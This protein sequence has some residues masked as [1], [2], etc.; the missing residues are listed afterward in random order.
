MPGPVGKH[1]SVRGR[2]NVSSTKATL[3]VD[4]D[5]EA[6]E[7]P[8]NIAWH[9]MVSR[10]WNDIWASPMAPEY[11]DSDVNGLFRRAVGVGSVCLSGLLAGVGAG[12]LIRAA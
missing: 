11:T 6:P 5:I 3:S 8:E 10:W 9:S 7:L 4:H 2:R 1:P 12:A